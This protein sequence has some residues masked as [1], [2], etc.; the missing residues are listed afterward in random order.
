MDDEE[1]ET[2]GRE[3]RMEDLFSPAHED[4]IVEDAASAPPPTVI[5]LP[6]Q[7]QVSKFGASE[8]AM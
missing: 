5:V 1:A 2:G 8:G 7:I 3:V 4:P 6:D